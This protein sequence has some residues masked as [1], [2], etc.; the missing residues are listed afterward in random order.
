[1]DWEGGL[2][3]P[4]P[5]GGTVTVEPAQEGGPEAGVGGSIS[6]AAHVVENFLAFGRGEAGLY[7][8]VGFI[9][10]VTWIHVLRLPPG[11]V[12][13]SVVFCLG[14]TASSARSAMWRAWS[15]S[16]RMAS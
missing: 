4:D 7:F 13:Q 8:C 15:R 10:F 1:M 14:F 12:G 3:E 2:V 6:T 5:R 9:P 16:L 11:W